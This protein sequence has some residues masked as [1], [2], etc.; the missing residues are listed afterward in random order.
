[1]L[2]Q[3]IPTCCRQWVLQEVLWASAG[4]TQLFHGQGAA[5]GFHVS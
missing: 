4:W 3:S 5:L 1:M 2:Y